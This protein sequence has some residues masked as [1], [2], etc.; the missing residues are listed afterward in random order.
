MIDLINKYR[1]SANRTWIHLSMKTDLL[2]GGREVICE[3]KDALVDVRCLK[4]GGLTCKR[5]INI[6]LCDICFLSGAVA[7]GWWIVHKI[8]GNS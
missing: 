8:M 3:C 4:R 2:V 7:I 5:D 6:R 1:N